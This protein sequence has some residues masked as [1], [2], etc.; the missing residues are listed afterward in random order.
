MSFAAATTGQVLL[1]AAAI[2]AAVVWLFFLKLR[3]PR[4]LIPSLVLWQSLLREERPESWWERVRR[5]VSLAIA[6][7]IALLIVIALGRPRTAAQAAGEDQPVTLVIDTSPT[8]MTRTSDGRTRWDNARERARALIESGEAAGVELLDTAATVV[9]PAAADTEQKL[10]ALDRMKVALSPRSAIGAIALSQASRRMYLVS[11]GVATSRVGDAVTPVSVFEPAENV[12]ITAFEIREVPSHPAAYEAYLEVVNYSERRRQVELRIGNPARPASASAIDLAPLEA[13]RETIDAAELEPGAVRADIASPGDSLDI[14]NTA[15]AY[16]PRREPARVLLVTPGSEYLETS[17]A[18]DP[19][20]ALTVIPPRQYRDGL[21]A[22]VF[23]FDRFVPP[24][25]PSGPALLFG[26]PAVP[27]IDG[28]GLDLGRPVIENPSVT[29][30]SP[31]H[32]VTRSVPLRDVTIRRAIGLAIRKRDRAEAV[33]SSGVRP[34]IVAG[35]DPRAAPGFS[36]AKWVIV[37]FPLEASDFGT[38]LGFP[39]FL[40]NVMA[41]FSTEQPPLPREPGVVSVPGQGVVVTT[42]D[43]RPVR[44]SRS[45]SVTVFDAAPGVYFARSNGETTPIVVGLTSRTVSDVNH[46][47]FRNVPAPSAAQRL[48]GRELWPT[49]L[50]IAM[51]LA[52]LEWFTYH[53]RITV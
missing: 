13:Y 50:L 37:G 39:I 36:R 7:A 30:T 22:D 51:G 2:A 5:A 43:G 38:Q 15:F 9:V 31:D 33:A 18:L 14:D 34:L 46:S 42:S 19:R 6:L 35:H 27:W 44:T 32:V 25:A 40:R 21:Q 52:T 4:I 10:A 49:L 20:V 24:A 12:G 11:D 1:L 3:H 45:S 28:V 47:A 53:R 41:W 8:M 48:G 26:L 29:T 17:L 23:I 16:L